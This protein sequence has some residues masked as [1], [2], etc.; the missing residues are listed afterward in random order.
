MYSDVKGNKRIIV[1]IV[2]I[3]LILMLALFF[4]VFKDSGRDLSDESALAIQEAVQ[5]GAIQ[6]Y[7][8]EG[9]YPPDLEY[10]ENN[11]GLKINTDDFYVTYDIFASNLPPKVIVTPKH[12]RGEVSFDE[13]DS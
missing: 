7:A 5:K 1:S 10:L 13:E 8:V 2:V 12:Q 11:Y 9:V 4:M 6:C 3:V